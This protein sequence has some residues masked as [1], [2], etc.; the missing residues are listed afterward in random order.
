MATKNAEAAKAAKQKKI[1]I[2]LG[3]GLLAV[4]GLQGPKLLGKK[5]KAAAP[6][7]TAATTTDPAASSATPAPVVPTAAPPEP[8]A[9]LPGEA[10][11]RSPRTTL[12]GVSISSG[13]T[14]RASQGQLASFS[15]FKPKDPFAP[16][17]T[18]A[19]GG[20]SATAKTTPAEATPTKPVDVPVPAPAPVVPETPVVNQPST[21]GNAD[22]VAPATPE[23]PPVVPVEPPRYATIS[24]NDVTE[25]V[26][27]GATFPKNEPM[28]MLA[29]VKPEL[30]R[31]GIDGGKLEKGATAPVEVGGSITLVDSA[32]GVRYVIKVISVGAQ[33]DLTFTSTAAPTTTPTST[34]VPS[35]P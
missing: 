1:L 16:Q 26:E 34:P 22:P 14:V 9:L 17:V 27:L 5:D 4:G 18:D 3:V 15:L 11:K 25:S 2:V 12:V 8:V 21:A 31:I 33:P 35:T 20:S 19:Q 32:S 29:R 10:G 23:K 24:V 28:F 30:V 13:G 6:A 7:P